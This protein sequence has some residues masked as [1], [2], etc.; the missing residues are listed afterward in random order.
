MSN[1]SNTVIDNI[2]DKLKEVSD[3]LWDNP[4]TA[5][6]ETKSAA[7][8]CKVLREEGFTVEEG[9]ADI[10]TAF[11][12]S[13]GNGKPVIAF[14]GEYDALSNLA[15]EAGIMEKSDDK[16]CPGH[17]CGHNLLGAGSLG[18]AIAVKR[19]LEQT[20]SPGTVVFFG[21]PGEEGGS[22]KAFMARDGVF[23]GVDVA[24]TWHPQ[25]EN[26]VNVNLNLANCQILYKFNGISS[27]AGTQPHLGRSA[28][29]A[30]ELMNVGVNFLREHMPMTA[31]IH[32]AITNTGGFSP[33]VVQSHAEV[34]YLIRS[35]DL[36][37]LAELRERV[38]NIA[39]GAALMTGTTVEKQLIKACSNAVTNHTLLSVLYDKMQEIGA[40]VPTEEDI[41][42]ASEFT[43]KALSQYKAANAEHPIRYDILPYNGTNVQSYGSSDVGDVSWV[44]PTAQ[45]TTATYPLGAPGHS[46]QKTSYGKS[47]LAH[48]ATLYAAKVLAAAAIEVMENEELLEKAKQEHKER[49]SPDGYICPIPKGVV[50][51][52]I[53]KL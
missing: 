23:D 32:Y 45:I 19:Y 27:H 8:L 22:G 2:Q 15:Q 52:A 31:R 20:K 34:L 24:F 29:D 9:L 44:C 12:G 11:S 36:S 42:F 5:F 47:N 6:S 35:A 37:D 4:E 16:G 1:F 21:C 3:F 50:P 41:S 10:A 25:S 13:F 7:Y 39:D 43:K 53:D 51:K 40:P 14:L 17:G 46:W 33:N 28:L 30:L 48:N 18:A 38:D 49:T 26:K